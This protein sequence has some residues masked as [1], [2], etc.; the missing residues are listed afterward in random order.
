MWQSHMHHGLIKEIRLCTVPKSLRI[1]FVVIRGY[2]VHSCA[3]ISMDEQ[4]LAFEL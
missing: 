2:Y 3:L 1:G 4:R